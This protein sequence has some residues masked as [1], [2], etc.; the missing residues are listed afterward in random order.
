M[1]KGFWSVPKSIAKHCDLS[2]RAKLIAGVLWTRKNNDFLAFPSR[3]YIAESLGVSTDTIDRG[4]EDLK[5]KAGLKVKRE[6][7]RRNN[8]YLIPKYWI[9]ESAE[10]QNLDSLNLQTQESAL[11]PTPIVRDEKKDITVVDETGSSACNIISFFKKRVQVIKG[12]NPEINWS[13]TYKLVRKRLGNYS[14]KEIK[15]L[16]DWYLYSK[17]SNRLGDSLMICLSSYIVN[18]WEASCVSH[19][20]FINKMY[21][22][23]KL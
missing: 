3:R 22:S 5:E 6:G 7:L 1:E 15:D 11:L 14:P 4:I 13:K 8:R 17:H 20:F 18:L 9:A 16:I 23:F 12:Y 10:M 21:P 2:F 19:Q